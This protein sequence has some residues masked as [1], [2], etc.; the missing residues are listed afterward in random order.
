MI[1]P[2]VQVLKRSLVIIIIFLVF[3]A[4][5]IA[6][7]FKLQIV[8][9]DYYLK[10]VTDQITVEG[11]VNAERGNI[12]DRNGN[13]LATNVT[14]YRVF[15]SPKDIQRVQEET[16]EKKMKIREAYT[17]ANMGAGV[18]TMSEAQMVAHALSQFLSV[19]YDEVMTKAAKLNRLDETIQRQVDADTADRLREFIAANDLSSEIH[20]EAGSKRYYCY[21]S[22]AANTIGF[23][24]SNGDGVLGIES[25][26]NSTLKGV[27]GRYIYAKD[28]HSQDMP[29]K[30]ESFIE[31]ENG[32]NIISTLDMR[33][34]YELE[35]QLKAAYE[36][37]APTKGVCGV[38]M[39]IKTGEI[40]GM[41]Q[42]PTF[43]LNTP[44]SVLSEY[45]IDELSKYD[46]ESEEYQKRYSEMLYN[47]WNNKTIT[48]RY[49]PGST[50][51]IITAAAALEEKAVSV[52][53]TFYCSGA[54]YVEGY[55][56]P[57]HCHRL[58]GHGKVTFAVGLQQSCNPTLME[59]NKRL[60]KELFYNYFENFGYAE[61][62]GVDLPSEYDTIRSTYEN[63]GPVELAIYSFGQTF[64][65]TVLQQLTALCGV[66]ND[67]KLVT[68][69]IVKEITDDSG[70]TVETFGTE[71]RRQVI[72][73]ATSELL[74][75]ILEE[76]VS[77]DGGARNAYVK[78]YKV[79]A[80]TGTSQKRDEEDQSLRVGSC[81]AFAPADDPEI[82]IIIVVD[83]PTMGNSYGSVV[84]A[85]Y[86]SKFLGTVLP[87]LGYEA[88]YT[89]EELENIDISVSNYKGVD[90]EYAKSDIKYRGIAVE[91]VGDGDKV[92]DQV[93][94]A[95]SSMS[96]ETGKIILYTGDETPKNTVTVPDVSGKLAVAANR[97]IINAGLNIKIEGALNVDSGSGAV[98]VNQSP[99]AGEVVPKGTVVTLEFRHMDGTD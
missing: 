78:G 54:Y 20:L 45:D 10:K 24:S 97:L 55:P 90:I 4:V 3:M 64:K 84:A 48:D 71:V 47:V 49:E 87:Y 58:V 15:I 95:G 75:Q 11:E 50:F 29:F 35:N 19:S 26:Y 8:K 62:T 70:S 72:S 61:T 14:V 66:A 57:I 52:D 7:L 69:H 67:G 42:Y 73:E 91:V 12:Y 36:S 33:I 51:K 28:A 32:N 25:R 22:L 21:G 30:Y 82:A 96:K 99:A 65:T 9:Y 98:V 93:P 80:K 34:Q 39:E 68:P 5:L 44:Y 59:T 1:R 94:K 17:L 83:E 60:G 16:S 88:E 13:L 37:S 40:L 85:P 56:D 41:G 92:V 53:D 74:M 27:A 89:E 23:V 18:A 46:S 2:G 6:N 43:D 76:G 79:A 31:P 86:V 81:V 38:V 77:G 63:M